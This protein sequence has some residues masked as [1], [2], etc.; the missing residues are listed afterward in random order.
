M[1]VPCLTKS[2]H[3]YASFLDCLS[4]WRACLPIEVNEHGPAW[5]KSFCSAIETTKR[6]SAA[7]LTT[8][9]RRVVVC[10]YHAGPPI[11]KIT[12]RCAPASGRVH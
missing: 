12:W 4:T 8:M 6:D 5:A 1:L 11:A 7:A 10:H 9:I 3:G 2:R